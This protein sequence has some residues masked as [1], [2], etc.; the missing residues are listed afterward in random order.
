MQKQL[1][2]AERMLKLRKE[3]DQQLRDNIA[4]ARREVRLIRATP[5]SAQMLT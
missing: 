3:Q 5:R 2:A 1:E 4:V